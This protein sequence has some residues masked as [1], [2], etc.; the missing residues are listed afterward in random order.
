VDDATFGAPFIDTDEWKVAPRRMRYVHGGFE[1]THTRFSFYFPPP[2][3][4]QGRFFQ[5]LEGGAGGHENLLAAG[6]QPGIELSWVFDLAFDE[7]GGYLVESNQGHFP[8]EGS[9]FANDVELWGASA[10]TAVLGRRLAAE[11]YG[12]EP[13]HGYIWGVSGGGARSGHC[14]E[15]R[16][17]IW[18]GGVPHA[19]IGQST[20]W[21]PWALAWL[22]AKDAFPRIIDATEPG[23]SGNPFAG[24]SHRER[25]ALADMYRRGYPRGAENQLAPFV[26]WAFPMYSTMD[27]DPTY[28]EDFWNEPGY[29]GHDDPD[30]IRHLVISEKTT[31]KHV[32]PASQMNDVFAQMHVRFA[33]AGANASDPSWGASFDAALADPDL[34]FMATVTILSGKAAGRE[35]LVCGV[36]GDVVSPFSERTPDVFEG[37][38]PGDEVLVDNR[39]FVAWAHYHRY[40]VEG[41]A[42]GDDD[43]VIPELQPWAVDGRAVYPPRPVRQISASAPTS[44]TAQIANKMIYVQPTLDNMVWPTTIFPYDRRVRTNLGGDV[45]EHYRLWFVENACHGA[46][47][48]IGPMNASEKDPGVWR[49]RLVPYDG[50]TAQALRD[51]VAWVEDDVAPP[52]Y[53]GFGLTRDNELVLPRTARERGGIQPVV[54]VDANG[55]RRAEVAVGEPVTFT[56]RAEQPSGTGTIVA[57]E[58]DF[59]GRGSWEAARL[60]TDRASELLDVSATHTYTEPGTYFASFRVDAHRDGPDGTGPPIQNL[61]RVRVVVRP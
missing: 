36:E 38:E 5:Y 57:A 25:E 41:G 13:H 44:Y 43:S 42:R 60:P 7:L 46:P 52:K 18:D 51:V 26:A 23:G 14:L 19:G 45:D 59:T 40:S 28:F 30:S 55:G 10:Q 29:L 47:E 56:A 61:A 33:T 58:W 54:A 27:A 20:Q 1:D 17:D 11:M 12:E 31:V 35:L 32:V 21:S 39:D 24:L 4:Y 15:Q 22:E 16:P 8:G 49:S 2:E 34:L 3:E 9:G 48:L 50:V 6:W 53:H 37:V